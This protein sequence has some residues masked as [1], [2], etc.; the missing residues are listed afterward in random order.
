[1]QKPEPICVHGLCKML[2][3]VDHQTE[4]L[5]MWCQRRLLEISWIEKMTNN[6]V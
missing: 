1:M 4:V 2:C 6:D 5:E 3:M